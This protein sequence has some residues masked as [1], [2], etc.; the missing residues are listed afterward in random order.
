MINLL[1]FSGKRAIVLMYHSVGDNDVFFTVKPAEFKKQ[2][3]YLHDYKFNVVSL[4]VLQQCLSQGVIPDKTVALT[5]DDGYED[6]FS[7]VLPIIKK[8]GFPVTI[9]LATELPHQGGQLTLLSYEQIKTMT[10]TGL[11]DFQPHTAHHLKLTKIP[12]S[13]AEQEI[14]ASRDFI[15]RQ[16]NKKSAYFAYPHGRYNDQIIGLLQRLG[17]QLG[18]TVESGSVKAADNKFQLKRNS[19]DSSVTMAQFKAMVKIGRV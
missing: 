17:F 8:L 5:F 19:V 13:E 3:D 10:E 7:I 9:F 16:L 1:P 11:V 12:I 18:F 14:V 4:P 6:N 2:M 15:S